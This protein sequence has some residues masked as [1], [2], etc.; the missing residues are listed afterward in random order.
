MVMMLSTPA[1]VDWMVSLATVGG[2]LAFFWEENGGFQAALAPVSSLASTASWLRQ[3][4]ET[5][6]FLRRQVR[7][8]VLWIWGERNLHSAR[9]Q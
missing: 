6:A 9:R 5:C 1:G 3:G 2:G 7:R 8:L 4:A